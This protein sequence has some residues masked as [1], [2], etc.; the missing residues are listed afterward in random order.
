MVI[1][2]CN[3]AVGCCLL[4]VV[5]VYGA[6]LFALHSY[7]VV[8]GIES[9]GVDSERGVVVIGKD[10]HQKS[11]SLGTSSSVPLAM[12]VVL[13]ESQMGTVRMTLH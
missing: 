11:T 2:W 3:A 10:G 8:N 12:T 1:E 13:A 7:C 4:L 9:V 6:H 5:V